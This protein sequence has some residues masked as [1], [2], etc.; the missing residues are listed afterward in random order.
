MS[1]FSTD[2]IIKIE[3]EKIIQPEY[4]IQCPKNLI[5]KVSKD[6]ERV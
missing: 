2:L 4:I 3:K 1:K 5:N 6:L